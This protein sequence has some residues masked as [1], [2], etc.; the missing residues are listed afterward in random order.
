MS[1][2]ILYKVNLIMKKLSLKDS[3]SC[4][5]S[6]KFK[7]NASEVI[8]SEGFSGFMFGEQKVKGTCAKCVQ[9]YCRQYQK[10]ELYS[11]KFAAFPKNTSYR[12]C[13]VDAI[14][15]GNNGVAV[16]DESSC[17]VCGLCLHRCPFAAIQ[18][19]LRTK[20]CSIN[21]DGESMLMSCSQDEA[22]EQISLLRNIKKN[23]L[24]D[25][26]S[27][28]FSGYYTAQIRKCTLS[29]PDISEII[30]RNTLTNLGCKCN[31]NASGNNHIRT[32]FFAESGDC[33]I[34]GESEIT[35][36]D[37]LSVTRRILDDLAV[38]ISRYNINK[39]KIVPLAI[40]NGLPNKRTDYYEVVEDINNV[41]H[42]KVATITYH[43]LFVLNLFNIALDDKELASFIVTRHDDN[44][45]I[46][47]KRLIPN[48]ESIDK[49]VGD[50]N[51]TPIK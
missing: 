46:G 9:Q 17:I 6:F 28:S 40:I 15:I 37:T 51:Y 5:Q 44:L 24:F 27:K 8:I 25:S 4:S 31:T 19:N 49:N 45:L 18:L 1:I 11:E 34:I 36:A 21:S 29:F 50:S 35:N 48:I 47:M 39:D 43:L 42:I 20:S 23:I 30:V 12:V 16:I 14:S 22:D 13:P 3:Y 41:L 2:S 10:S 26:I 7:E 38:L 33:I 32:E